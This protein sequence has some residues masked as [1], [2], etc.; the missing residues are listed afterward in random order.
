MA[1][2]AA[3]WHLVMRHA[4][5]IAGVEEVD[6][7]T[8]DVDCGEVELSETLPPVK[9]PAMNSP[10]ATRRIYMVEAYTGSQGKICMT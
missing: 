6:A 7:G 3:D 2:G 8:R 1:N 5:E 9:S 10:L 4:V